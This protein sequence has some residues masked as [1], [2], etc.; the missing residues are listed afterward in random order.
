MTPLYLIIKAD[1]NNRF[2]VSLPTSI[3]NAPFY[4]GHQ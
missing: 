3:R 1:C 2:I 4:N